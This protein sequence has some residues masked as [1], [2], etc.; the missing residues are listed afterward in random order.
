MTFGQSIRTCLS[1]YATFSGRAQRSEF[2][3]FILFVWLVSIALSI[4]DSTLFGT[5]VVTDTGFSASTNTPIFSGIFSL[6]MLLPNLAV[7]A[8]RLHDTNRSGW[9]L[10]IGLIPLIGFIV[11]IVFFATQ[12]TRGA[13]RFG[14]DPLG[15]AGSGDGDG[16]DFSR[17]RVPPVSGH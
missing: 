8:R 1:K 3:W 6:A 10:L 9:W 5:T 17:S 4:V 11:L 2:W 13:N 12:G 15:H 16:G 14:P 7:G